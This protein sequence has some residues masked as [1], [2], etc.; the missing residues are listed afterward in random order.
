MENYTSI[1]IGPINET[2]T[3]FR[4]LSEANKAILDRIFVSCIVCLI[5]IA[6]V[7]MGSEV[8]NDMN[9]GSEYGHLSYIPFRL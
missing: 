6:N 1:P 2:S 9:N 5:T 3:D 4:L 8:M 7:L